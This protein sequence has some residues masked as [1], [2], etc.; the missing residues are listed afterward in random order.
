M[1]KEVRSVISRS[2]GTL[3]Q[4]FIGLTALVV[5]LMASL[6]LPVFA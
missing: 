3:V 5:I 2:S 4:D 6:F 1:I